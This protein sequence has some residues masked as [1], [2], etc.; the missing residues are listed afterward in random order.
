MS[1]RKKAIKGGFWVLVQQFGSR[2]IGFVVSILLARLLVPEEYGLI[3]ML[4]IFMAISSSIM[5]GGLLDSLI[6]T[7]NPSDE[8]YSTVFFFN[9][10][11][12]I[13]MYSIIY[14]IAPLIADF[15][16]EDILI[17]LVR[18]YALI[19][20]INAFTFIQKTRLTKIMD[21]KTQTIVELPSIVISATVGIVMAYQ[22]Y[23]VWCLVVMALV[24]AVASSIQLWYRSRWKPLMVFDKKLFYHHFNYGYK[25]TLS[26]ILNAVFSNAYNIIIGKYFSAVQLGFYNRAD[27]L[28][29]FPVSN[30]SG[31]LNRVTFPLFAE[32]K[33]DNVRL[34]SVYKKLMKLVVFIIAPLLLFMSALGE[35]TFRFLFTDK[36]LPA[37]PYFQILCFNGILEPVHSYNMNILTVKGRSDLY[38]KLQIVKKTFILIVVAISFSFGIYGLLY[39]SVF[40]SFLFF[41]INSHFAGKFISY[42]AWEQTK[43]LIPILLTALVC[44][45]VIFISDFYI[46]NYISYDIVRIIIGGIIGSLLYLLI[47]LKLKMD[48]LTELMNIIKRK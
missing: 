7:D 46:K 9:L 21:F 45:G 15:Y 17:I 34:K 10:I 35:P 32:I 14:L 8:E 22:G 1:L 36:W 48:S 40:L 2:G 16:K 30:I 19:L 33:N 5:D 6:R 13:V 38:L 24:Q 20:V 37:V 29:Q 23:G 27:S 42:S 3:A 31:V 26:G 47:A 44:A 12:S 39:G 43:D 4:S 28:K 18:Y 25:L 11:M 41:V